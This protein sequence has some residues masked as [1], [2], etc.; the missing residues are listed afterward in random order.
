MEEEQLLR[1]SLGNQFFLIGLSED[2]QGHENGFLENSIRAGEHRGPVSDVFSCADL[3]LNVS[4]LDMCQ[5][6]LGRFFYALFYHPFFFPSIQE[7]AMGHAFTEKLRSGDMSRSVGAV[8]MTREG[9]FVQGAYNEVPKAG[10]GVYQGSEAFD[11]RDWP[12]N[13]NTNFEIKKDLFNQVVGFLQK[14]T[15]TDFQQFLSDDMLDKLKMRTNFMDILEYSRNVH[16]EMNVLMAC[17]R[18]GIPTQGLDLYSTTFP[19][20]ACAKHIIAA[21]IGQVIYL[22]PFPKSRAAAL[23]QDSISLG[24]LRDQH[25]IPFKV[26]TGVAPHRLS[27]YL[28]PK[29]ED[30]H[31]HKSL[32]VPRYKLP[33][34]TLF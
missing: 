17:A 20:H 9:N 21:G 10:G 7:V 8:L 22:D 28:P 3:Y 13:L 33:V 15:A 30:S 24:P 26:Y 31:G 14:E 34:K 19:C 16:G 4:D 2:G 18:L 6:T 32:W 27:L 23:F 12:Q 1:S 11:G 5:D 25:H 29:R